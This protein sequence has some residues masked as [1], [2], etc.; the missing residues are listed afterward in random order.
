MG[1]DNQAAIWLHRYAILTSGA[2]LLLVAA[3]GLV[4]SMEAGLA[5]PDWPLS[6][7]QLMPPMEGG[8]LYEHGHRMIGALV[9]LLTIGL[10]IW[11]WR[12]SGPRWLK[13]LGWAALAAVVVQGILGGVTVLLKL[14]PAV[15]MSHAALAQLFFS[16]TVVI[17]RATSPEWSREPEVV[18][19][20]GSP[21]LRM[22]AWV[23]PPAIVVQL[24]LGAGYRHKVLGIVP[25][26]AGALLVGGLVLLTAISVLGVAGSDR[27]LARTARRLLWLTG[28][29]IV[30]GI[31]AYLS[32]ILLDE[33][34]QPHPVMV[35]F[36]V[37]HLAVGA[38]LLATSFVLALEVERAV[39]RAPQTAAA[40]GV[41]TAG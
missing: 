22:L 15:S 33:S 1:S 30:L 9:G 34:A 5:V 6:F 3:G 37:V 35:V 25:H 23:G 38:L 20:T 2:T 29:Q 7:G 32:R 40:D 4:K 12:S 36:T 27:P 11:L 28:I 18:F 8:V 39:R 14:P 24:L 17:A 41:G 13:T 21:S 10:A 26:I 16:A 19:D 31:A